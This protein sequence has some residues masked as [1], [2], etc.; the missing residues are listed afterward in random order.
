MMLR[1][2]DLRVRLGD[3]E[4][5]RGVD[6]E[7]EAGSWVT[8]IGPNG[9]GK[10]TLLRA[11]LD[12]VGA[13]GHR[14]VAGRNLAE[15]DGRERA[16][17]M[18]LVPQIPEMP[19]AMRV[20]D[21]LL[22]GR[23]PHLGMLGVESAEDLAIVGDV[24]AQLD[25]E[26]LADRPLAQI[27]GGERQRAVIGRALVQQVQLLFLD[28]PTS[29]LDL[30]HQQDVLELIESLRHEHGLTII[31]TMHDLNLAGDFADR[32][33]LLADGRVEATGSP[34]TVLDPAVLGATFGTAVDVIEHEGRMVVLPRRSER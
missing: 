17:L 22:L 11:L 24:L 27:S 18:A 19:P 6:L 13:S 21:Y 32:L 34:E 20:T 23:T 12:L 3:R 29:A 9:A 10:T 7:V 2:V 30:G 28:E 26:Q 8:I 33:V 5:V 4:V 25:L 15:I 14:E 31:S 1:C 16:R